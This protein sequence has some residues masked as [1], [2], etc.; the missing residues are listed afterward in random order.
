M[1][2]CFKDFIV[3]NMMMQSDFNFDNSF[4]S[5]NF[6]ISK[7]I[8]H[9][10][11]SYVLDFCACS[12]GAYPMQMDNQS[13]YTCDRQKRLVDGKLIGALGRRETSAG[14]Y[15]PNVR[16]PRQPKAGRL[17]GRAAPSPLLH[18]RGCASRA[19]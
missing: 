11:M 13:Q 6:F 15:G 16:T 9:V 4:S 5:Y 3:K 1:G 10:R 7:N 19:S 14:D 18:V 17:P 2:S 8:I 12:L